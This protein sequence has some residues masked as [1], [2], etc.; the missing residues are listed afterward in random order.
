MTP[1]PR[2]VPPAP[3][4]ARGPAPLPG[5]AAIS[6]VCGDRMTVRYHTRQG[7]QVPDHVAAW[8]TVSTSTIECWRKH[9]LLPECP[10]NDRHCCLYEIPDTPPTKQQGRKLSNRLPGPGVALYRTR[11]VQYE[12]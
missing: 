4:P 5:L 10:Y 1:A 7:R 12:A 9:G 8:L 2:S 6:G 3:R 11:E